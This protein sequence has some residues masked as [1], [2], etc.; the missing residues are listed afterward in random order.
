MIGESIRYYRQRNNMTQ[1]ELGEKLGLSRVAITSW[2]SNRTKPNSGYVEQMANIF[3]VR[4]TD[5][6]GSEYLTDTESTVIEC[7]RRADKDTRDM[8]MR[9]L[10]YSERINNEA[11]KTE[12]R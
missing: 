1:E 6:I 11:D 4:K 8:V 12:K 5:L 2:E 9:L 7:F 10:Q 3:G